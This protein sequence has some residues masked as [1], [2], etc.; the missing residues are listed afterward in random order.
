MSRALVI[1]EG[2]LALVRDLVPLGGAANL[3]EPGPDLGARIACS[4]Q[5]GIVL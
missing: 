5:R 3:A 2:R 4:I 1:D